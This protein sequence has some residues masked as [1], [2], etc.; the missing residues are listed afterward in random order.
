MA[1]R[2]TS[3]NTFHST[4]YS[5]ADQRKHQSSA[6]RPFVPGIHRWPVNYPHKWTVTRKVFPFDD[7][8]M[9][10]NYKA[11][12]KVIYQSCHMILP[13]GNQGIIDMEW[14]MIY[15]EIKGAQYMQVFYNPKLCNVIHGVSI[16]ATALVRDCTGLIY[17]MDKYNIFHELCICVCRV[18]FCV[19]VSH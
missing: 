13:A 3:I 14:W 11:I 2:I 7:V 6:S 8:I 15:S 16:T 17:L 4:V 5:G 1:S 19:V 18:F 10:I 9:T 12:L